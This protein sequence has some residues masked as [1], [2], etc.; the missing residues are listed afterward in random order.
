MKSRAPNAAEKSHMN[1]V[2]S[3]PCIACEKDRM[4]NPY[5]SLHHIDGRTKPGAHFKVLPLCAQHHQHDDSD[6]MGRVGVH[7]Y[8]ARFENMYGTSEQLLKEISEKM[9]IK[10]G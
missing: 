3:M 7:P 4:H 5:I 6:L 8:K 10:H 1:L 2:G 9:G